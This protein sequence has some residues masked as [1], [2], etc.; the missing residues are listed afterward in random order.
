MSV[1]GVDIGSPDLCTA[2]EHSNHLKGNDIAQVEERPALELSDLSQSALAGPIGFPASAEQHK[3]H[4]RTVLA[5]L[6]WCFFTYGLIDG[7]DG[8]LLPAYQ[9]DYKVHWCPLS[10]W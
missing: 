5:A 10:N 4:Y 1:T 9:R 7:S 3:F 8:P 6:F 2:E